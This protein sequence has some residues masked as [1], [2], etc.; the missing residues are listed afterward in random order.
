M[1]A[2]TKLTAHLVARAHL[3]DEARAFRS[4]GLARQAKIAKTLCKK[5][6]RNCR[7]L[8]LASIIRGV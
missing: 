7:R 1:E 6:C 5:V 3:P 8:P 2:G 4:V